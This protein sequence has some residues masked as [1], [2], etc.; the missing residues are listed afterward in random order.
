MGKL[1]QGI[2]LAINHSADF[3][4][5]GQ[6]LISGASRKLCRVSEKLFAANEKLFEVNEKLSGA[7][8]ILSRQF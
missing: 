3:S 2:Q 5:K 1:K 8:E 6:S 4:L 7:G